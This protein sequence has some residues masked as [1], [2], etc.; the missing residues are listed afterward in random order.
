MY[1]EL[2][3]KLYNDNIEFINDEF[4]I[5][6]VNIELIHTSHDAPSSVG[7]IIYYQEKSL[8]YGI[9]QSTVQVQSQNLVIHKFLLSDFQ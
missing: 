9:G 7:Y 3:D 8:V 1:E 4:K 6:D 5:N 2:K